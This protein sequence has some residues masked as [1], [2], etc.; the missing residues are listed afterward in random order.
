MKTPSSIKTA[1]QVLR[2]KVLFVNANFGLADEENENFPNKKD[3]DKIKAATRL[4]VKAWVIPILDEL[5][6]GNLKM[7]EFLCQGHKKTPME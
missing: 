3:T 6:K 5:E 2:S 1:C 4:Y 7:V